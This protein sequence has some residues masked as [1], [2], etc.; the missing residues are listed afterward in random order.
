MAGY[1]P[2]DFQLLFSTKK[3]NRFTQGNRLVFHLSGIGG[4]TAHDFNFLSGGDSGLYAAAHVQ[5]TDPDA[6]YS[7]WIAVPE[8]A[9]LLLLG[10]GLIGLVALRRKIAK[11]P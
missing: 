2:Y 11:T 6:E 1:P 10:F 9:S 4:L 5:A 7:A 8:P 3:A